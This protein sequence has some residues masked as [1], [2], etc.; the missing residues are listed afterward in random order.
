MISTQQEC[1]KILA[2][3]IK[4]EY[5]FNEYEL[6]PTKLKEMTL[7]MYNVIEQNRINQSMVDKFFT[8]LHCGKLGMFYKQ[9]ISFLS[10][11]YKFYESNNK[12][13]AR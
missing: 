13:L 10:V 7:V 5:E 3:K 6:T 1:L 11:F 12:H 9:P 8:D 2:D 4:V